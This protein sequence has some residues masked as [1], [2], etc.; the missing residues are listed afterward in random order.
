[1]VINK[2]LAANADLVRKILRLNKNQSEAVVLNPDVVGSLTCRR[3][4][5]YYFKYFSVSFYCLLLG[6]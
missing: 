1:M 2:A 6:I 4:G 5:K 3:K